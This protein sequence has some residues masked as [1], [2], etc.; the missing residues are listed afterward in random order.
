[1]GIDTVITY[2]CVPKER[3]TT[4]GL[5]ERIKA[6][7][8]A[9]EFIQF[10]RVNND[11]RPID[12]MGGEVML[13]S[14]DG[15]EEVKTIMVKDLLAQRAELGDVEQHCAGCPANRSGAPFGCIGRINYPIS[16][17]AEVW[18]LAQLPDQQDPLPFLLLTRAEEFGFTGKVAHQL[19]GDSPGVI[20]ETLD[21]LGRRFSTMEITGNQLFELFFLMGEV[22]PIKRAV[23][24]LLFMHAIPRDLDADK[25]MSLTPAPADP[26]PFL[27]QHEDS[28]DASIRDIKNFLHALYLAYTLDRELYVDV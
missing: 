20:F 28:D 5:L 24:I 17:L 11:T 26:L 16:Q 12:E 22:I 8:R 7:E 13:R 27:H 1:M 10:Y 21:T 4:Q 2:G 14:A 25:L 9:Q 6:G 3:F 15:E 23:M 18:M 19:R